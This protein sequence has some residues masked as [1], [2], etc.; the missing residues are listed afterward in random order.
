[1][2][3]VYF[4]VKCVQCFFLCRQHFVQMLNPQLLAEALA[5]KLKHTSLFYCYWGL[6]L[7]KDK[8]S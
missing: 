1:M 4:S 8:L 7:Y 5:C 2:M 3:W 6:F